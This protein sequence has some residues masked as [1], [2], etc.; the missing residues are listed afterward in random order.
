MNDKNVNALD[1]GVYLKNES[2]VMIVTYPCVVVVV[3]SLLLLLLEICDSTIVR[4]PTFQN[5]VLPWF[6]H[7]NE[8][9]Q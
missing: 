5:K 1:V 6:Q 3:T 9:Q 2:I 4:S 8:Q 7:A